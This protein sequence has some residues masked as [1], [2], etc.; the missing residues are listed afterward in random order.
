VLERM[1]GTRVVGEAVATM[2]ADAQ[3][4]T[5]QITLRFAFDELL[6]FGDLDRSLVS[7]Y[8][9]HAVVVRD[10]SFF[11]AWLSVEAGAELL[12]RHCEWPPPPPEE[13]PTQAQGA[14]AGIPTKIWFTPTRWLFVVQS[15]YVQDFE[16]RVQ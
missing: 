11:G 14:V 4:P 12:E 8:D 15:P 10:A 1:A 9:P 13:F 7:Q 2:M 3:W 16:D 6:T 5:D